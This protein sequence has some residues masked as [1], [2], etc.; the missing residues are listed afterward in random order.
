MTDAP[1][2]PRVPPLLVPPPLPGRR[3]LRLVPPAPRPPASP[4]RRF[5][6]G[7]AVSVVLGSAGTFLLL[8]MPGLLP[9]SIANA[10][11]VL[12]G[13]PDRLAAF[14]DSSWGAALWV[15]L[16]WGVPFAPI[17]ALLTWRRPRAEPV[18]AWLL[19]FALTFAWA[20]AVAFCVLLAR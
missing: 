9:L 11:I 1:P 4:L 14:R 2:P 19:A 16:L 12:A 5:L 3:R 17:L 8:G 10:A 6:A 15:T 7:L 18:I 13:G 20:V